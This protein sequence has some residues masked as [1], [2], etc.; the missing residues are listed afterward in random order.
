MMGQQA[1][2]TDSYFDGQDY[3]DN[4]PYTLIVDKGVITKIIP[5]SHGIEGETHHHRFV[6]PG[7]VESHCHLFL[8]GAELD[9]SVRNNYLKVPAEQMLEVATANTAQ[10]LAAGITL[11]R[12]AGDQYGINHRIRDR[13][14][15]PVIR[16]AG[17]A[18]RR[19]KRYGSFMAREVGSG[20]EI[21]AAVREIA[22]TADD[23]KIIETGIIDFAEGCVK[24]EPQFDLSALS[25]IV[26]TARECG[27]KTFAH[28]SGAEG[29]DVAIQAGVDSIEHGFFIT[30]DQIGQLA[31]RGIAW[32][33]TF[34]PVDFQWQRPGLVG[35]DADTVANLSNILDG[36]YRSVAMAGDKGVNLVAGSDAGSMGVVHGKALIDE[37][38][39]F[40]RAG[41]SM[42]QVLRS[43][44]SVPRKLWQAESADIRVGNKVDIVALAESPFVNA[45]NLWKA[46]AVYHGQNRTAC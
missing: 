36:H 28:C 15:S 37:L 18:L 17:L 22:E 4:G 13:V 40:L 34:S 14:Q 24:G 2:I 20:R 32:V 38:F 26:Y 45:D 29:I 12:D 25:L 30:P 10:S 27:L 44:T 46:E 16:S 23:L 3:Q 7:M 41:L 31:D 21:I 39:F 42:T 35:W 6:M 8:D 19:P 43:V 33:P 11:I 5:G 1:I 9:L